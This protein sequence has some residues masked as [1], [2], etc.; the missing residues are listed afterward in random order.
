MPVVLSFIMIMFTSSGSGDSPGASGCS[1]CFLL[2]LDFSLRFEMTDYPPSSRIVTSV[3][4]TPPLAHLHRLSCPLDRF[5]LSSRTKREISKPGSQDP[6]TKAGP[7]SGCKGGTHCFG[8]PPVASRRSP[9]SL[10]LL[11]FSRWSK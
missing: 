11:D 5:P 7:S 8:Y 1:P 4:S 6:I 10:L 2:L 3:I 9:W